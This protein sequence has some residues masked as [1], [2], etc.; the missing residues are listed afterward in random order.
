VVYALQGRL[1][2]V[3]VV[4]F[5]SDNL[6]PDERNLEMREQV[7]DGV[8]R[9][10]GARKKPRIFFAVTGFGDR[11]GVSMTSVSGASNVYL[12]TLVPYHPGVLRRFVRGREILSAVDQRTAI[13]LAQCAYMDGLAALCE[14]PL[15]RDTGVLPI[16]IGATGAIA[17]E[18][19][20]PGSPD[21]MWLAARTPRSL[22]TGFVKFEKGLDDGVKDAQTEAA[23]EYVLNVALALAGEE[24]FDMNGPIVADQS[25][26]MDGGKHVKLEAVQPPK[27]EGTGPF[28]ILPDGTVTKK[29]GWLTCDKWGFFR[30]SF[31]SLHPGHFTTIDS[32]RALQ[33][34]RALDVVLHMTRVNARKTS[35]E[36]GELAQRSVLAR[37]LCPILVEEGPAL[38]IDS[39]RT[40]P[41]FHQIVGFDTA[42][43]IL[44]P[45]FYGNSRA[46][47]VAAVREMERLGIH[48]HVLGRKQP[49][50]RFCDE[51]D[52]IVP[53]GCHNFTGLGGR[54]DIS[55]TELLA[56][57]AA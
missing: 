47:M 3:N 28:A 52:L 34:K 57:D 44:N 48:F 2:I 32:F 27:L 4:F 17:S 41:G 12:G 50:G 14:Q 40:Y 30:G 42:D 24:Q 26:V 33:K 18:S 55:S 6:F 39:A 20:K 37:E 8:R 13:L 49:D 43:D 16:G 21:R 10:I 53:N 15:D 51:E 46:A 7:R 25:A 5:F 35:V 22:L 11:P 45:H 54:I 56:W 9:L 1:L 31:R 19:R 29:L 38:F 23:S 36:L